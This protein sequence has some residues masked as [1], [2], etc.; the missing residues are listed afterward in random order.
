VYSVA[1]VRVG[2]NVGTINNVWNRGERLR[3]RADP[4]EYKK[5]IQDREQQQ[6]LTK[7]KGENSILEKRNLKW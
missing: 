7:V 2:R 1:N 3:H 6:E 5:K 4:D